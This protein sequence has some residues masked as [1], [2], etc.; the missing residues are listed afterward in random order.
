MATYLT[1]KRTLLLIPLIVLTVLVVAIFDTQPSVESLAPFDTAE[2]RDIEQIIADNSPAY[3]QQSESD[4]SLDSDSLNL[5]TNFA[6][7]QIQTLKGS[8]IRFTIDEDTANTRL[9]IPQSLGPVDFYLNIRARFAQQDGRAQLQSLHF[10]QLPVPLIVQRS[11]EK[12]AGFRLQAASPAS[13]ELASLRTNIKDYQLR[14]DRLYLKVQWEPETLEQIRTYSQ[15]MLVPPEGQQ[16]IVE[17]VRQINLITSSLE[18]QRR[19]SLVTLLP[20]LF[21]FAAQR[22]HDDAAQENRA[23]LQAMSLF[24]TDTP[25][26]QALSS[27]VSVE[28]PTLPAIRTSLYRRE[29]LS[30]HFINSAAMAASTNPDVAEVLAN[31]KEVYDARLRSG[32]SFSDLAANLAGVRLGEI[33]V[34]NQDSALW[35]QSYMQTL[36][37]ESQLLPRPRTDA[38]GLSESDFAES[39]IDRNSPAY[40]Q[41]LQEIET[42]IDALPLYQE[43]PERQPQE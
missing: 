34:H 5:L 13:Q 15:Q 36:T 6:L 37:E 18:G 35:L 12:L 9:A 8:A 41:R 27:S 29:D 1:S 33:A 4:L 25:L 32:F 43:A 17:Y 7:Q 21:A 38:D 26:T 24:V 14:N 31:S 22:S 11:V 10:G 3:G 19:I 23:L 16:R 40:Q 20:E 28:T 42:M 2:I 39:F 30:Q